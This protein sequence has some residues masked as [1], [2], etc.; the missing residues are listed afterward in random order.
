MLAIDRARGR[1]TGGSSTI[2]CLLSL[3]VNG[4]GLFLKLL[5]RTADIAAGLWFERNRHAATLPPSAERKT[6]SSQPERGREHGPEKWKPV[7]RKDH[8]QSKG[9]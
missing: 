1:R 8:A 7:F 2:N 3:F 4:F 9:S 6:A 5:G